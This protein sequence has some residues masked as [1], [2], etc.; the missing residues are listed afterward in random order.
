[1]LEPVSAANFMLSG[2]T[3]KKADV[4]SSVVEGKSSSLPAAASAPP[5]P[6]Q[7][8]EEGQKKETDEGGA[9]EPEGGG[10]EGKDKTAVKEGEGEVDKPLTDPNTEVNVK[11]ATD[12]PSEEMEVDQEPKAEEADKPVI[13]EGNVKEEEDAKAVLRKKRKEV[14]LSPLSSEEEQVR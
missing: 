12:K 11:P 6:T 2:N 4:P 9:G 14:I 8:G 10:G 1:M 5:Q 13:K 3:E 7:A